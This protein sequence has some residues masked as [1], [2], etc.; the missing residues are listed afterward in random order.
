MQEPFVGPR[1]FTDERGMEFRED[2]SG[3]HPYRAVKDGKWLRLVSV[4]P[5]LSQSMDN[6]GVPVGGVGAAPSASP[7]QKPLPGWWLASDGRWYPPESTANENLI[8]PGQILVAIGEISCTPTQVSIPG[9]V[10]PISGLTWQVRENVYVEKHISTAGVV[11]AI[12]FVWV[13]LLGLLFLLMQE[14][15]TRGTVDVTITDANGLYFV[16]SIPIRSVA[17]VAAIRAQ[18]H[19]ARSLSG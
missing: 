4:G 9:R 13:C 15:T 16:T 7:P 1:G 17:D 14:E 11:L 10:V 3:R 18:V 5:G 12:L 2:P 8:S 6:G 19:Y